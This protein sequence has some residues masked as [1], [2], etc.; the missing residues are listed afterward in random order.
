MLDAPRWINWKTRQRANGK[1]VKVPVNPKTKRIFAKGSNYLYDPSCWATYDEA[2]ATGLDVGFVLGDTWAGIDLDDVVDPNTSAIAGWAQRVVRCFDDAYLEISPSGTGLKLFCHGVIDKFDKMV[3]KTAGVEVYDRGRFFTVTERGIGLMPNTLPDCSP[4]L[5]VLYHQLKGG[6]VFE[7]FEL[8]SLVDR[9]VDHADAN[10]YVNVTCPWASDHTTGSV[11]SATVL[12]VTDGDADG[13]KCLHAHC[14]E[15]TIGD[16]RQWLNVKRWGDD[17]LPDGDEANSQKNLR[18]ALTKLGVTLAYDEFADVI[19]VEWPDRYEGPLNDAVA[20]D[21]WFALDETFK[22]QPDVSFYLRFLGML[23][24]ERTHH[25]VRTY[26][27]GLKWDGTPRIDRW[28]TTHLG[29]DDTPLTR[30][31][32]STWLR[33]A[34]NRA[35]EPGCKFDEM[36]TLIDPRQG[37]YK[38]TAL[39]TLVPRPEWFTDSLPIGVDAKQTIERTVGIWI[40]EISDLQGQHRRAQEEVKAFMSRQADGPVRLAYARIPVR[41]PRC[42]VL[43]G[44][45]NV[46]Q[47]LK[48]QTGNRRFWGVKIGRIDVEGLRRDRDQLWAEATHRKDESIRLDPS[49]WDAAAKQQDEHLMEDPYYI[50]LHRLLQH[51]TDTP[52]DRI[53]LEHPFGLLGIPM[54]RRTPVLMERLALIMQKLG[55]EKK[56]ARG[57]NGDREV[58][59]RWVLK[60]VAGPLV[61]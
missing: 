24:R 40:A 51:H 58:A 25:P 28:L 23:A 60:R 43:A 53:R 61:A 22:L 42:F 5:T 31:Y 36:L 10:G 16:V 15:R 13:F 17:V 21:L 4:K 14:V 47:F 44:S 19:S 34:V 29:V 1:S 39:S 57:V 52:M 55:Y 18:G 27:R 59:R 35:F 12:H 50:E 38:S 45:T 3:K 26:L 8:R 54:D 9:A 41:R 56:P 6:N 49:L 11:S 37:S 48:D 7:L 20:D 30:G 32:G 33:A 46:Q 2:K